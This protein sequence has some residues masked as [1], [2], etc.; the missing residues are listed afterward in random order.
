MA[1]FR[2]LST[3]KLMDFNS[4]KAKFKKKKNDV[5]WVAMEFVHKNSFS[6]RFDLWKS[7]SLGE[8]VKVKNTDLTL[9]TGHITYWK[10]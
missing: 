10:K 4:H 3:K 2:N 8:I 7:Y 6:I 1:Q 5:K 9:N